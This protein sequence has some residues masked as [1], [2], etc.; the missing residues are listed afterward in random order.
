MTAQQTSSSNDHDIRVLCTGDFQLGKSF[1][2]LGASGPTF[3]KQLMK[4]AEQVLLAA[5][6]VDL[7]LI[8]GDT[9]D[10]AA[11]P[12]RLIEDFADMLARCPTRV[13]L[14]GGNHDNLS[15][16]IPGVLATALEQRGAD[17]VT[18]AMERVPVVYDDL[19]LTVFPSSLLTRGDLTNQ[20]DWMPERRDG[21][22]AR[23][24]LLHGA[25]KTLPGGTIPEDLAARQDLDMV[26]LGDQHGPQ[27]GD[28]AE[29]ALFDLEASKR[30]RLLYAMSPEAMSIN[31]GFTGSFTLMTLQASTGEVE[32]ERV[33]CGQLRFHKRA[34]TFDLDSD[35]SSVLE[36]ALEAINDRPPELTS[37]RFL[38]QGTI[39]P[40]AKASLTT[41]LKQLKAVWPLFKIDDEVQVQDLDDTPSAEDDQA[42]HPVLQALLNQMESMDVSPEV[43]ERASALFLLN[44]GGWI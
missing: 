44:Q 4:T 28:P 5:A 40:E 14:I 31:Q 21:D 43:V 38:L 6:Q 15:T 2:T 18:V 1:S 33:Q 36:A 20:W 8:A 41:A 29:S 11:T 26:V 37:V 9:F 34:L 16:G 19:G 39:T 32:L 23:I 22:G 12:T 10:R 30:R 24:A 35:A 17:H 3:R 25:I 7:V 42:T 27:G 13:L